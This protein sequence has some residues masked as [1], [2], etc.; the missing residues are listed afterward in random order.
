M[1]PFSVLLSV[2]QIQA[3]RGH[4]E[5]A[6]LEQTQRK[7]ILLLVLQ[8]LRLQPSLLSVPENK[9]T[10]ALPTCGL[11]PIG[12]HCPQ[13]PGPWLCQTPATLTPLWCGHI[14]GTQ[15]PGAHTE[16]TQSE[17]GFWQNPVKLGAQDEVPP[18]LARAPQFSLI[19]L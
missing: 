15:L 19:L 8:I 10:K 3:L 17:R 13:E 7:S 18:V 2:A 9:R 12:K 6:W 1:K 4:R 11:T 5:E 16:L 14:A